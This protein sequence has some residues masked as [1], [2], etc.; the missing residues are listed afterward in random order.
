VGS[1]LFSG[2]YFTLNSYNNADVASDFYIATSAQMSPRFV[3][4]FWGPTR[5]QNA[6][7][8]AHYNVEF[9]SA[10]ACA[11]YLAGDQMMEQGNTAVVQTNLTALLLGP[12]VQGPLTALN[13]VI[14]PMTAAPST[15]VTTLDDYRESTWTPTIVSAGG[16]SPTYTKR[17]G[18]YTKIGNLVTVHFNITWTAFTGGSGA[19]NIT[20]LPLASE[21]T[22]DFYGVVSIPYMQGMTLTAN[23]V[24]GGIIAPNSQI[25]AL[26]QTP[27][28][29]GNSVSVTLDTDGTLIGSA[30]YRT[31]Q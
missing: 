6:A 26:F 8:F 13:G 5:T 16:G 14:F 17:I 20:G 23:N 15:N 21:N 29:G 3:G 25:I 9:Q 10:G 19:M 2:C 7:Y 31:A 22:A 27:V 4:C 30:T 18:Y 12:Y 11:A 24:L 1:C 28:G